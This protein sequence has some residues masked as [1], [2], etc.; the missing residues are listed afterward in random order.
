MQ[1]LSG[2]MWRVIEVHTTDEIP[3]GPSPMG[4]VMFEAE[5][6]MAAIGDG[7]LSLP[8]D[9]PP[10]Y[11][12]AYT[13]SYHFDG[14]ELVTRVDGASSADYLGSEQTRY[15]RFE[16][17]SRMVMSLTREALDGGAGLSGVWERVR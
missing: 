5:R 6:M 9:A 7:R 3:L 13:G 15:I 4:F 12:L 1:S 10:R 17:P 11:F 2:T 16:S 8:P 14:T